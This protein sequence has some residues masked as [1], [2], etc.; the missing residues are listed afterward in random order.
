MSDEAWQ[1]L[2]DL[3]NLCV[4]MD[5]EGLGSGPLEHPMPLAGGTQNVL[6]RF[7]R[8]GRPYVLRRSPRHPRGAAMPPTGAKPASSARWRQPTF[9]IRD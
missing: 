4:W 1:E 7:E 6:L 5:G 3:D 8:N 9:R 2:V